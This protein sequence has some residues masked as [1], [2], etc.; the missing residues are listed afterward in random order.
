MQAKKEHSEYNSP[1]ASK[2]IY[3]KRRK[4][5]KLSSSPI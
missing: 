1:I 5:R 3:E 4:K 2:N